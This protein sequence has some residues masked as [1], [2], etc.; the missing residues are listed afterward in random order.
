MS[1]R[2]HDR[3]TTITAAA[4][5]AGL[6]ASGC[7]ARQ[8]YPEIPDRAGRIGPALGAYA[9]E[10]CHAARP[11]GHVPDYAF[12]NDGCSMWPDGSWGTCCVEHD[13]DYWCGGT[14]AARV[15]ADL[16]L[17][18]CVA[19]GGKRPH[20][21]DLMYWGVRVGGIPWQPF[22]WRWAYGFLGVRGY[23]PSR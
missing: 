1:M 13:V 6:L 15:R 3:T 9:A 10:V 11:T 14:H 20:L 17:R 22:P 5:V 4:F 12:T 18:S 19:D 16:S 8:V 7:V 23:E 21:G 2:R